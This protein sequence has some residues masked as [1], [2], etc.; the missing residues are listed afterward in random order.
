MSKR[1]DNT[2]KSMVFGDT[3]K[4]LDKLASD[5]KRDKE[6]QAKRRKGT[7]HIDRSN[8]LKKEDL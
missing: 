2:L 7:G 3:Q 5:K 1:S 4:A 8:H 6:Y